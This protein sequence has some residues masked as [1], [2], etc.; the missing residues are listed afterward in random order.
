MIHVCQFKM[1]SVLVQSLRHGHQH[2][3]ARSS[4]NPFVFMHAICGPEQAFSGPEPAS[5]GQEANP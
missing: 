4:R 3:T 5:M 1:E 2:S